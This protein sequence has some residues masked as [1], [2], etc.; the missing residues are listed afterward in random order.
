MGQ[1]M[2]LNLVRAGADP[3]VFDISSSALDTLVREGA[4]AAPSI[5]GVPA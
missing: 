1:R 3:L 2:A 5:L 4:R